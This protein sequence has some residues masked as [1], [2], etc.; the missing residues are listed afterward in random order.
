[1]PS[2]CDDLIF[3]FLTPKEMWCFARTNR[4]A[5]DRVKLYHFDVHSIARTL[6]LWF[7]ESDLTSFRDM[8]RCTG[9]VIS[10]SVALSFFDRRSFQG[11]DLDLYVTLSGC[12]EAVVF[13]LM[14]GYRWKIRGRNILS[15]LKSSKEIYRCRA[16]TEWDQRKF[17]G[18]YRTRGICS[19][20][21][22][23]NNEDAQVQIIIAQYSIIDLIL[24]F[25]SVL[26]MNIITWSHAICLY[27]YSSFEMRLSLQSSLACYKS[28]QS[29]IRQKYTLRGFTITDNPGYFL[30][31]AE[32]NQRLRYIGDKFSW[33][34][35]LMHLPGRS[36]YIGDISANSWQIIPRARRDPCGNLIKMAYSMTN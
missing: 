8:Q 14:R 35:P 17:L 9:L 31:I 36:K 27:P 24:N 10:G 21:T 28:K 20:L 16:K 13:L 30:G 4:E 5:Y 7:R 34:L 19:V 29:I 25:H 26:M 33:V 32:Y 2:Q 12:Q 18:P 3:N 15:S 11:N 6:Q 1:S 22:F 23:I